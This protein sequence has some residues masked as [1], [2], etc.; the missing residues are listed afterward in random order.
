MDPGVYVG[1][2]TSDEYRLLGLDYKDFDT[3]PPLNAGES[4]EFVFMIESLPL[5]P[6]N[7][8]L[9]LHLKDMAK[10]PGGICFADVL[11]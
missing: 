1:V 9:E 10:L 11:L 7:Y 4:A 8:N 2:L 3:H 5:L 6:G